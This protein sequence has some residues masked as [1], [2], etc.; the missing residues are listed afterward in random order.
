MKTLPTDGRNICYQLQF[1]KCGKSRCSTC[2]NGRGHGPY[3][4]AY[5]RDDGRVV[6]KYMG[7]EKPEE[8]TA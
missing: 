3:T 7:K 1:R 5:W 4:Y 6:S 8:A 2:R